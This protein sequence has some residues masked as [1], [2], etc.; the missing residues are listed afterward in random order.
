VNGRE[1]KGAVDG[2]EKEEGDVRGDEEKKAM[3]AL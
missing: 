1:R 3:K 2:G